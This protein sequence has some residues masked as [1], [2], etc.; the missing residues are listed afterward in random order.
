MNR[1]LH[2]PSQ[3]PTLATA[4]FGSRSDLYQRFSGFELSVRNRE[5]NQAHPGQERPV[6]RLKC[7]PESRPC[8]TTGTGCLPGAVVESNATDVC[9]GRHG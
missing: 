9:G 5:A 1:T 7:L 4:R 3:E 6:T 8:G 2:L